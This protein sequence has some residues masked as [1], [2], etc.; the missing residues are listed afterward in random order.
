MNNPS[1]NLPPPPKF[2]SQSTGQGPATVDDWMQFIRWLYQLYGRTVDNIGATQSIAFNATPHPAMSADALMGQAQVL[3]QPSIPEAQGVVLT[4][5]QPPIT[6]PRVDELDA[7]TT[8]AISRQPLRSTSG[9]G[10][11]IEDTHAHRV[12]NYPATNYPVGQGFF[13]TDRQVRYLVELVGG[14]NVWGYQSGVYRTVHTNIP[15]DLGTYDAG[16]LFA[17]TTFDHTLCWTGTGWNFNEGDQSQ[18]IAMGS[19]AGPP[20]GGIW[21]PC[22][23][24]T[25]QCL[26][27]DGTTAMVL[28]QNLNGQVVMIT[29]GGFSTSLRLASSPSLLGNVGVAIAN[30]GDAGVLV[31]VAGVGTLAALN[32]HTHALTVTQPIINPPNDGNGGLPMHYA[33]SSWF[34]RA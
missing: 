9:S 22:D 14:V 30:D 23:G 13:E 32:P 1:S 8:L 3:R 24:G 21:H 6:A 5:N 4:P 26:N 16:F 15:V 28:T 20:T 19:S 11:D 27:P 7:L 29:G 18:Y 33:G 34:L 2:A 25:Y 17:D 10:L 31:A 12:A